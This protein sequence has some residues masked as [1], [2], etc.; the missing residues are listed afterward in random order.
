MQIYE[1]QPGIMADWK[2]I[3]DIWYIHS[4][5]QKCRAQ[6]EIMAD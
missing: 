1:T 5:L 3:S 2:L 4:V 6:P